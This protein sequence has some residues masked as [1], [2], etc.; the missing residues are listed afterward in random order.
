MLRTVKPKTA[1]SKRALKNR[2]PKLVENVKSAMFL[3]ALTSSQLVN[4]AMADLAS[5]KKPFCVQLQ[6]NN[7]IH[8]FEDASPLE[9]LSQKNDASLFVFGSHSKKRPHH[10]TIG[11]TFDGRLLDQVELALEN[12]RFMREFNSSGGCGLGQK[13]LFVFSGEQ[14]EQREE[15]KTLRSLL[16]D[17]YRGE[18]ADKICLTGLEHV[19]SIT[20]DPVR[21]GKIALRVYSVQLKKSGTRVPRI[22]LVEM[23]P[24][25]DFTI[26][27]VR[28]ADPD[29]LKLA[30]RKPKEL[31]VKKV[32]NI[33]RDEMGDKFGRIHVGKQDI[34]KLQTRKM[35]GLKR[36]RSTAETDKVESE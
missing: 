14:F 2:E 32:K 13:P 27:R 7:D 9:F 18:T 36:R 16:L 35:K 17:F 21:E 30:M 4:D 8:P 29:V 10:L 3:K 22:E 20:A 11:R 6:K 23:G 33:D 15:Y 26:D 12:P 5:L 1:R 28:L 19:I 24:S 25:F 34:S 31:T